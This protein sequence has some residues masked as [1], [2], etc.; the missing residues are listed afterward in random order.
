MIKHFVKVAK[1]REILPE[2]FAMQEKSGYNKQSI[3]EF[4][5]KVYDYLECN[6]QEMAEDEEEEQVHMLQMPRKAREKMI[7][8]LH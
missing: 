2:F 7:L 3:W 5:R 8:L 1:G 4:N 6:I